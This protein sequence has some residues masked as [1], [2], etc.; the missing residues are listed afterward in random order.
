MNIGQQCLPLGPSLDQIF[1]LFNFKTGPI[2]SITLSLFRPNDIRFCLHYTIC[3]A[4]RAIC[5]VLYLQYPMCNFLWLMEQ[6]AICCIEYLMCN[7]P[8]EIFQFQLPRYNM[9]Y[10]H[11][12]MPYLHITYLHSSKITYFQPEENV[13]DF[14]TQHICLARAGG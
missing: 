2:L 9:Q 13:R 10:Y 12:F 14:V 8:F 1:F 5:C 3:Q 11:D 4:H 7:L 6:Q